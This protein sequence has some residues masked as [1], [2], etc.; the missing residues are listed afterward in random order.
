MEKKLLLVFS[1]ALTLCSFLWS[2][3]DEGP[4]V[5]A[6]DSQASLLSDFLNSEYG[7]AT[8]ENHGLTI[9]NLDLGNST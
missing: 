5:P 9:A 6:N 1:L 8:L 3:T 2:C 7:I 4:K